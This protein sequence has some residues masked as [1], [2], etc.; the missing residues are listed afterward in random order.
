M[1]EI[2]YDND[3]NNNVICTLMNALGEMKVGFTKVIAGWAVTR[4]SDEEF[5]AGTWG[6]PN[7]MIGMESMAEALA[8]ST[9]S[10]PP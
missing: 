3:G 9:N 7:R 1:F 4:W 6:N 2:F 8:S 5:E 10:N